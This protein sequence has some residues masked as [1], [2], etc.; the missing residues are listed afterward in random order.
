LVAG[1]AASTATSTTCTA[2][3]RP[4]VAGAVASITGAVTATAGAAVSPI[5]GSIVAFGAV[6]NSCTTVTHGRKR[7]ARR[8]TYRGR[9]SGKTCCLNPATRAD[10][11]L[12]PVERRAAH[13]KLAAAAHDVVD[14]DQQRI[15]EVLDHVHERHR[16]PCRA[17]THT[18]IAQ[19]ARARELA[20]ARRAQQRV[21]VAEWLHGLTATST[22]SAR[23]WCAS[24]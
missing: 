11:N 1:A 24:Q 13:G 21:T 3:A 9:G 12:E 8:A 22:T 6:D 15:A 4:S 10:T 2:G 14:A 20:A 5:A 7:G 19:L 16:E 23:N 18:H 17:H